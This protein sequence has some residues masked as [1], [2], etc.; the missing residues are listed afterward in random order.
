MP[1]SLA[2]SQY[3]AEVVSVYWQLAILGYQLQS[4]TPLG[5]MTPLGSGLQT[6]IG[7]LES[8]TRSDPA[9]GLLLVQLQQAGDSA[10]TAESLV[11]RVVLL[12]RL[13]A[14]LTR[15]DPSAARRLAPTLPALHTLLIDLLLAANRGGALTRSQLS[16]AYSLAFGVPRPLVALAGADAVLRGAASVALAVQSLEQSSA[17]AVSG[18]TVKRSGT[19][20]TASASASASVGRVPDMSPRPLAGGAAATASGGI[21]SGAPAAVAL[22]ALLAVWLLHAL[23]PGRAVLDLV[24]WRSTLLASRLER[25]G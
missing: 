16:A 25:P 23:L 20:R 19:A 15:V 5:S 17:Q 11:A 3:Q 8:L 4:V 14:Y 21:A 10:P 22:L 1:A 18:A 9:V 24:P 6:L 7:G 2:A 13:L 12:N